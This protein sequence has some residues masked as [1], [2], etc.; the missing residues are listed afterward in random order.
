MIQITL[1]SCEEDMISLRKSSTSS[2]D[3]NHELVASVRSV[4]IS[5]KDPSGMVLK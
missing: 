3:A 4:P 5:P 2:L 1:H